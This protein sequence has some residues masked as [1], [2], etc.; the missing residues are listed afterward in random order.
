MKKTAWRRVL[1]I[2]LAMS[3]VFQNSIVINAGEEIAPVSTEAGT[4]TQINAQAEADAAEQAAAQAEA[5]AKAQAEA[6]AAAQAAAAAQ[7]EAEAKAQ[8]EA[9][10]AEQAAAQAEAEAKAQA[11]AEAKAQAEAEAKAQAEAEA[12]AQA[13]A[14]AKAQAEAEAAAQ[15]EAE[16]KAQAEA[17]AAAQAEAEAKAQAE[18]E[19][20]KAAAQAAEQAKAESEAESSRQS[21]AES[22]AEADAND[23]ETEQLTSNETQPDTEKET[24]AETEKATEKVTYRVQFGAMADEHGLIRVKDGNGIE[25]DITV[26]NYYKEVETDGTFVFKVVPDEGYKVDHVK[27]EDREVP[28]TENEYKVEHIIKN[29]EINVS[30]QEITDET[31]LE[32]ETTEQ[33]F[34]V[35]FQESVLE[36]GTEAYLNGTEG[37]DHSWLVLE[38]GPVQ[39]LDDSTGALGHIRAVKEGTAF[40]SHSYKLEDNISYE[41]TFTVKVTAAEEAAEMPAVSASET[42]DGVNVTVSA[43]EGVLPIGTEITITAAEPVEGA[44][45]E[46]ENS[47]AEDLEINS[48]SAVRVVLKDQNGEKVEPEGAVNVTFDGVASEEG[49]VLGAVYQK[50]SAGNEIATAEA[51][52]PISLTQENANARYSLMNLTSGPATI[53]ISGPTEVE[54]GKTI[55]LTSDVHNGSNH[56]WTSSTDDGKATVEGKKNKRLGTTYYTGEVT[57]VAPGTV[58]ITHT[59]YTGN[60]QHTEEYGSLTVE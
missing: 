36:V 54:V 12:A 20:A 4:E 15:A 11:E 55:T 25:Q 53:A 60:Q 39:I 5:E 45:S 19:A 58:T 28:K 42:I 24:A 38:D 30:Y 13:E 47:V 40:V 2:V 9:E 7:A 3:M 32:S 51:G 56:Q 22:Q 33:E 14:E 50:E 59:Y 23:N 44:V 26:G 17:E 16:A 35:D 41:E 29:I 43:A 8:A 27:V 46:I 18:A 21:E 10:A 57:G 34:T 37:T 52:E 6:E 49:A 48:S 1:A 31:E